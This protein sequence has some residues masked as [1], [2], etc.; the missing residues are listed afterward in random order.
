M[1]IRLVVELELIESV[2]NK[3]LGIVLNDI[4]HTN[5]NNNHGLRGRPTI[6]G[7]N[8]HWLLNLSYNL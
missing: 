8:M 6:Y 7:P 1:W 5:H 4:N 2:V 3:P